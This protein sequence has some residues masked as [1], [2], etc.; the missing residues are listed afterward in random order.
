MWKIPAFVDDL[1]FFILVVIDLLIEAGVFPNAGEFF[2]R[3]SGS[4]GEY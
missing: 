2:E 4:K 1:N 3:G